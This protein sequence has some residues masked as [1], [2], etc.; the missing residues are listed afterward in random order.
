MFSELQIID[1]I[2]KREKDKLWKSHTHVTWIMKSTWTFLSCSRNSQMEVHLISHFPLLKVI[3]ILLSKC[4]AQHICH[5]R[6]S[7]RREKSEEYASRFVLLIFSTLFGIMHIVI[8]MYHS[9]LRLDL[10]WFRHSWYTTFTKSQMM[11][12]YFIFIKK[13]CANDTEYK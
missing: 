3:T 5:Q 6:E 12:I 1:R 9:P 13:W 11:K 8:A 4:R 10:C 2:E 7:V